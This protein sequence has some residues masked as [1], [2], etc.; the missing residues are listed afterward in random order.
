MVN[1]TPQTGGHE[2]DVSPGDVA[3]TVFDVG[4][5]GGTD[6]LWAQLLQ[7]NGQLTGWEPFTRDGAGS[8]AA[9]AVRAKPVRRDPRRQHRALHLVTIADP[10]HVGFQKLELWDSNGT[11]AGGQFVINGVAQ[12]GGHE[13]DVA[14]GDIAEH[15]VRRGHI[16]RHRPAV[17]AAPAEQ[18]PAHGLDAVHRGRAGGA[19]ADALACTSSAGATPRP[20]I[21]SR[22]LVRI[23][24][25]DHVGYQKLELW[26]SF[27]GT[28]RRAVRD[29][30]RGANRRARD[31]R[32]SRRCRQQ[33]IRRGHVGCI[34]TRCGHG[35]SRTMAALTA[36]QPF[37]VKD[38]ITI[39]AGAT[40]EISSAY[41]GAVSFA[42][43][44]GTL[45][46]DNS[47]SF[48]GTV[49]GMTGSDSIDFADIDPTKVQT[50][51]Y[52]GDASGGT[53]SVSD[54][55]HSAN[56][57]LLGNYLA[58]TFA[59]ASDGHGGTAVTDPAVLG[60]VAPLVTPPHA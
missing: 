12:T 57:A 50:P 38:P 56:I 14:P 59:A 28:R 36:W 49:A 55:T 33:Q 46:L 24:D 58:S 42:A 7:A 45:Q 15:R 43:G 34:P 27:G 40:V 48:T 29:Q 11:A 17:G 31:R 2:I 32:Q 6:T 35:F 37:T 4:T 16:G 10:D 39:A 44:T 51:S 3:N 1:G 25:P 19:A 13:I 22:T 8:A 30:R 18:R 26:D 60:G 21:R 9:D 47:A 53:L 5:L 52:T 20:T 23:A 41:A 54:G